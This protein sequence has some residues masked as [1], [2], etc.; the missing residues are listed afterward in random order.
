MR[1]LKTRFFLDLGGGP[2]DCVF[3]AGS[4]RSGTTWVGDILNYRNEYRMIFEPFWRNEVSLVSH[5]HARQYLPPD[6]T[7]PAF[8]EPARRIL[9]GEVRD[10]WFDVLNTKWIAR[11][12]LIKDI[13]AN[14]LLGWIRAQFPMTPIILLLRH[15]C[16]VAASTLK[17]GWN[18]PLN[19]FLD[20]TDLIDTHLAPQRELIERTHESGTQ[21]EKRI[22]IWC[23]ENHVALSSGVEHVVHYEDL[24]RE[25]PRPAIAGMFEFL[26][27][28]F[29]EAVFAAMRRPSKL[30]TAQ[31]AVV[32][33]GNL[34][35]SWRK[36]VSAEQLDRAL[37]LLA[38]FGLDRIYGADSYPLADST[39]APL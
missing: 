11:R 19:G 33:G 34:V 18:D 39:S 4:G 12:R 17:M 27:K 14:L 23:A 2:E 36:H 5:F 26:G 1:S 38:E 28:P 3:L 10:P 35:D 32:T 6:C 37:E 30:S 24:C 13:R 16:A 7:D 29:D 22:V 8:I 25:D 20:Q 9:S 15:P 31:S 21:F